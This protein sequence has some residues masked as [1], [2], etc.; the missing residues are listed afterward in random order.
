[1]LDNFIN[2]ENCWR[3]LQVKKQRRSEL[4][5]ERGE[6]GEGKGVDRYEIIPSQRYTLCGGGKSAVWPQSAIGIA[7]ELHRKSHF[8]SCREANCIF[9]FQFHIICTYWKNQKC[10][11]TSFS[12]IGKDRNVKSHYCHIILTFFTLFSH[13]VHTLENTEM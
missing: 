8:G 12:R 1:M 6:T 9:D 2:G 10:Q 7:A 4:S 13:Y 3:M 5:P 11:I